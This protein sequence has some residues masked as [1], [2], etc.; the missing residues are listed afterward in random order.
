MLLFMLKPPKTIKE[1]GGV[2]Q[3][4]YNNS[5]I[6]SITRNMNASFAGMYKSLQKLSS[7][8]KINSAADGPAQLMIS[9][10]FRTQIATLNQQIENT[11]MQIGKYSTGSA[12][13][14]AMRSQLTEMRTM[15]VGAANEGGNSEAAQQA[16][17][18]SATLLE[19]NFNL[20]LNRSEYNGAVLFDG[21][22]GSLASLNDL[23]GV[24]LSSADSANASIT[25]IDEKIAE[26]DAAVVDIGA[27]QKNTLE[28]DIASMRISRENLMAAE[29][30]IRATDYARE[31]SN[32]LVEQIKAKS[33][34]ALLSH[35]S[36]TSKSV[37]S[38][39]GD[40]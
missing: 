23:A 35:Y 34:I 8:M 2:I 15:A 10:Q 26:I 16:Y 9:E 6:L 27:T 32:F 1:G 14:S 18:D 37:L 40:R 38:M 36:L 20:T 33:S 39:F 24:D 5:S 30:N 22:E 11:S 25:L 17:A 29:A 21:S 31:F 4:I 12:N 3:S 19:S 7:G 13:L 28:A